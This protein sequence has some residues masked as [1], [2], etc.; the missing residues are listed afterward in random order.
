MA[1]ERSMVALLVAATAAVSVHATTQCTFAT[2]TPSPCPI[3]GQLCNER[4]LCAKGLY[5]KANTIGEDGKSFSGV[6]TSDP[7]IVSVRGAPSGG[8]ESGVHPLLH[9]H[10][11]H[12][13]ACAGVRQAVHAGS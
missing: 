6:C 3:A 12:P 9:T 8:G 13:P 1:R 7:D 2:A 10:T 4:V 11:P 5:C